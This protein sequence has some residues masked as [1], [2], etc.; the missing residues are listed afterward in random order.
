MTADDKQQT[1]HCSRQKAS[2]PDEMDKNAF[3]AG[4]EATDSFRRAPKYTGRGIAR[5]W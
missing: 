1:R 3:L 5:D 4:H 2:S